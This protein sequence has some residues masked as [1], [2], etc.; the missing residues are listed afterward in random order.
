MIRFESGG[1]SQS[2]E[3]SLALVAA[4]EDRSV[5]LHAQTGQIR[6][7][8]GRLEHG[9]A[10]RLGR[11][12]PYPLRKPALQVRLSAFSDG[13]PV[14]AVCLLD[15]GKSIGEIGDQ[16]RDLLFQLV[17]APLGFRSR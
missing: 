16:G 5:F 9:P 13:P 6:R 12:T 8:R 11:L 17:A 7:R 10:H 15:G 14:I 3:I 2:V 4:G 1:E